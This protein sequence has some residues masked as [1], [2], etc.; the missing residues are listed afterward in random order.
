MNE[1]S[2]LP[3]LFCVRSFVAGEM[4]EKDSHYVQ[5]NEDVQLK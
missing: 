3:D 2:Q 4:G 1:S 5:E